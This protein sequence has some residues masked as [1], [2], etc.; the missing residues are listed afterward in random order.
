MAVLTALLPIL[1]MSAPSAVATDRSSN[2]T[3]LDALLAFKSQLSDPSRMLASNWTS[4]R[5][6]ALELPGVPLQGELAPHLGNLSFLH[7]LNLTSTDL[8]GSGPDHLGRLHRLV[9]LDLGRNSLSGTIPSAIGNLTRL[10]TL[11][12]GYNQFNGQI[13]NELLSLHDLRNLSLRANYLSG[14]V[15]KFSA[16]S[17][18][19]LS[20]LYLDNNTLSGCIPNGIGSLPLLRFLWLRYN[21]LTGQAPSNIFNMSRLEIMALGR[22]NLNGPIPG[23]ESFKLPMLQEIDFYKNKFTAATAHRDLYRGNF[24]VGPIPGVLSNLSKLQ[25]LDISFANLSGQ[26]PVELG[27]MRQLT[28]LHLASNELTGSFPASLGNLSRLIFFLP[29]TLGNTRSLLYL[30]IRSNNF[31]GNLDFLESLGNCRELQFLAISFNPCTSGSLNPYYVAN[32]STEVAFGLAQGLGNLLGVE[33]I[34]NNII[35]SLPATMS[36]LSALYFVSLQNNQLINGIPESLAMLENLNVLDLSMNSMSGPI[37][38]KIGPNRFS[39]SILNGIDNLTMLQ[40]MDLSYNNLSSTIPANLFHL[41]NIVTLHLSNNFFSGAL[42][43]DLS[44]MSMLDQ[45]DLSMNRL[46][47]S[48]PNSF[49]NQQIFAMTYFNL[50]HNSLE[51]SIPESFRHLANLEILD[52]SSNNLSGSVPNYLASFTHLSTLNLSFNDLEGEIPKGGVFSNLTLQSLMGN[53]RLCGGTPGLGFP[54]C[55]GRPHPTHGRHLIKFVIPAATLLFGATIAFLFY[56]IRRKK[57]MKSPGDEA[58]ADMADVIGHRQRGKNLLGVGSFGKVF[59]GQLGDAMIVAIKVLNMEIAQAARSFEA[60]CKALR[61]ARHRNLIRILSTCSNLDF[62]A[63]VLQYMPN[64]SLD[65][66]LHVESRPCM[67]FSKRLSVRLDVSVAMEYLHHGHH[68]VVLH[69]DLKPSNVLFDEEMNVRV[70][71]FGIAKLLLGDNNSMVSAS[72]PGTVGYMA[73]EY[74]FMG[75]ASQKSDVF[76]LGIMPLEVFTGK[77]PTDPMFVGGLSLRQWVSEAFP[78]RLIDVVDDRLLRP[79][80]E[81][82]RLICFHHHHQQTN[83]YPGSSHCSASTANDLVASIFELGLVCSSES[84]EQRV[85]MDE[86]AAKLKDIVKAY[87]ARVQAVRQINNKSM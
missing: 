33:A 27:I 53:V 16:A 58:S 4:E 69:C 2:N 21:Q 77:R 18:P 30:K 13:P 85:A 3:D 15:P 28:N 78:A 25:T 50:S 37:L 82:A 49:G 67:V 68:E 8:V 29:S 70:A 11:D 10:Q 73:P 20:H 79:D 72:M 45:L 1:A 24:L 64:G 19:L 59:K 52:L 84:P 6:T 57:I 48:L 22:N 36:N 9:S 23:N 39:G 66:H 54:P 12:L 60:E 75:K 14:L 42:P 47:G 26:I 71:D 32:L 43:S 46:V 35:G 55:L 76:S 34:E 17:T 5:V 62:K 87:S 41:D 61:M 40:Q 38:T 51:D 31:G 56:L 65:E 63:L 83:S 80:E 81:G 86:V 44:Y 7:V 74:A